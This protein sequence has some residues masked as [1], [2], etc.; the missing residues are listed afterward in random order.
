MRSLFA[1]LCVKYL[2]TVKD[3]RLTFKG[4]LEHRATSGL[5][6]LAGYSDTDW[7]MCSTD[8]KY[9]SRNVLYFNGVFVARLTQKQLVVATSSTEAVY[10]AMS[11][12]CEDG[13]GRYFTNKMLQDKD[14]THS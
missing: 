6:S 12:A 8:S 5:S 3:R 4:G 7:A 1:D 13:L 11:D 9:H 10:I 2:N 14:A